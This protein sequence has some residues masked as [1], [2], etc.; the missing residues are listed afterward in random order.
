MSLL[1]RP[2]ARRSFA[3]T[4]KKYDQLHEDGSIDDPMPFDSRI[5]Y[6]APSSSAIVV[7]QQRR[8]DQAQPL[9]AISKNALP[10]SPVSVLTSFPI[11]EEGKGEAKPVNDSADTPESEDYDED[12]DED[13]RAS[14]GS[15]ATAPEPESIV[16][17]PKDKI[18]VNV[19]ESSHHRSN[20]NI[21]DYA[22]DPQDSS[23]FE[24]I[25][26]SSTPWERFSLNSDLFTS[27]RKAAT[28]VV[29]QTSSII[30]AGQNMLNKTV[31][32]EK[33]LFS[34]DKVSE[35]VEDEVA[36]GA[37]DVTEEVAAAAAAAASPQIYSDPLLSEETTVPF[38]TEDIP[39]S[40]TNSD[41]SSSAFPAS[42][43]DAC[44]CAEQ[45][46]ETGKE[47]V[48][49]AY[50]TT[51]KVASELLETKQS[52][53]EG[54]KEQSK[55]A[56]HLT[57]LDSATMKDFEEF[58][59]YHQALLEKHLPCIGCRNQKRPSAITDPIPEIGIEVQI[60]PKVTSRNSF[61]QEHE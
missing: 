20:D 22:E 61:N 14:P 48:G 37:K 53:K 36:K 58:V 54:A 56:E 13:D 31:L 9:E 2:K 5:S 43:Q 55:L 16:S 24:D 15:L 35:D 46:V 11:T 44:Q 1:P 6:S 27:T 28:D 10:N 59:E 51:Q 3:S 17:F 33:A 42:V 19:P 34:E 32:S 25:S 40:T 52:T 30:Q 49:N 8:E 26:L 57:C 38:E 29:E 47:Y 39:K 18:A 21:D 4:V 41:G 50:H 23:G 60:K 12:E 45:L 7:D